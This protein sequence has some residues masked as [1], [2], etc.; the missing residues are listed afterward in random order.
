VFGCG[1]GSGLAE[2]SDVN[3]SRKVAGLP[4]RVPIGAMSLQGRMVVEI[5]GGF[6]EE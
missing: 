4:I 3:D 2:D 1:E 6:V 5:G